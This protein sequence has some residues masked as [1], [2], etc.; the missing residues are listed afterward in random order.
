MTMEQAERLHAYMENFEAGSASIEN[1]TKLFKELNKHEMYLTV[2]RLYYK[3]ALDK[4]V[5]LPGFDNMMC[6]FDYAKDHVE[7]MKAIQ[8]PNG[9]SLEDDLFAL[10]N[11]E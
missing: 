6:Q 4:N 2:I 5:H 1:A 3:H 8:G 11:P 10:N 7:G 9:Q